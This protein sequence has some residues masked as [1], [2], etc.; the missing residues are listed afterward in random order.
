MLVSLDRIARAERLRDYFD[1]QLRFAQAVAEVGGLPIADAIAR[2][3]NFHRR[4]GLGR[5]QDVPCSAEW[6]RYSRQLSLLQTHEQQVEW[7]HAFF[8][9]SP[10]ESPPATQRQFGCFSCDPPNEQGMVR[11]HFTNRDNH[12]GT[13]PLNR[14]KIGR[15]KR[16]L[17]EMFMYVRSTYPSAKSVK[18][19]SWLYHLQAYR[20]LFPLEYAESREILKVGLR[21][22]GTSSWGQF[23]DH[24]ECI[25]P[26][27]RDVFLRNIR[28]LDMDNLWRAFPLPALGTNAPIQV[29]YDFYHH[30][31]T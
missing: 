30:E 25:R 9:Q 24:R 16:E 17:K 10:E 11:I 27:L 6:A 4:F 19:G 5:L 3:T 1:L 8:L 18:G 31:L 15:R 14:A 22:D 2:Y 7:T 13:G 21:F 28:D 23:L 20:R 12:N 29:F 26:A